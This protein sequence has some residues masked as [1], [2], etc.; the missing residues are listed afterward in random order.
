VESEGQPSRV[1]SVERVVYDR[2]GDV[3]RRETWTT[4][5]RSEPKLVRV[6]TKERPRPAPETTPV[7]PEV[8]PKPDAGVTTPAETTP[9]P[10]DRPDD[11][12]PTQ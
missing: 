12:P 2:E 8:E 11:P 6:G 9:T 1:V 3:L 5:Y 7:K 4:S 10:P